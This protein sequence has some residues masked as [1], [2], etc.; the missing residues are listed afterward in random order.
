MWSPARRA[1]AA[2]QASAQ[3]ASAGV[4][5]Y[6][7]AKRGAALLEATLPDASPVVGRCAHEVVCSLDRV[8]ASVLRGA[9]C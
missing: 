8:V 1:S 5:A 7:F 9:A 6:A 3:I 4:Y 2:A